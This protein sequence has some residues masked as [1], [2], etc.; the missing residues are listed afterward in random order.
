MRPWIT[1]FSHTGSEIASISRRLNTTP[2]K[3]ITNKPFDAPDLNPDLHDVC[4]VPKRPTIDDYHDMFKDHAD[5]LITMHGWMRVIP[6][7]I[8]KQ[9][10][11]INLHPGLITRYPELKGKD[12]QRKVF[13]MHNT[14]SRVGCVIHRAIGQVD[15]GEVLME[16]STHNVFPNSDVLTRHLHWMAS[17]MWCDYLYYHTD[18]FDCDDDTQENTTDQS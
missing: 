10:D 4:F 16:R 7:E 18:L 11:I 5:A 6:D 2:D 8:C 15:S 13:D 3:I 1:M 12:P 17:Y 14:P 9:Y